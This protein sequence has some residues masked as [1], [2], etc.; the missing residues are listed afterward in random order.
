M[1]GLKNNLDKDS[2]VLGVKVKDYGECAYCSD[3]D[4]KEILKIPWDIWSQWLYISQRMGDK[5]WGAV[6]WIKD[7]T[8]TEFKIP[9]QEVNSTECEFKEDLGGDGIIHS[10]HEMEAFHSSQDDRHARNLYIYS[11]VITNSK[12]CAA[13][14][15]TK[16][17]CKGFGYVKVELRLVGCPDIELSKISQKEALYLV[18]ED[19]QKQLDFKSQKLPCDNC[20][21]QD[22]QNCSQTHMLNLSCDNCVTLRCKDCEWAARMDICRELPFCDFCGDYLLCASC[23]QLAKYLEN[24]PEDRKRFEPQMSDKTGRPERRR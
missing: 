24:Y 7:S 20:V 23:E 6:F 15:R 21:T 10:H 8:I 16:L 17:P 14:K 18:Q 5:E 3:E 12:G 2:N 19:T 13:T 1:S 4:N 22:C 9:R 11:I